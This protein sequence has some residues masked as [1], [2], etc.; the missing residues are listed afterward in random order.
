M[1]PALGGGRIADAGKFTSVRGGGEARQLPLW[2]ELPKICAAMR[3]LWVSG[4]S[5][6]LSQSIARVGD[7]TGRGAAR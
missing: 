6:R 3:E 4:G 2:R 5:G 1:G 7:Q